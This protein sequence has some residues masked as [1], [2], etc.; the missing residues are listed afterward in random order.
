SGTVSALRKGALRMSSDA[1]I[2]K[3]EGWEE[4]L[5]DVDV[6]GTRSI[7]RDLGALK[8]QLEN[9]EPDG[10]RVRAIMSRLADATMK[11]ADKA[12][13]RSSE[14]I[15]NLGEVLEEAVEEAGDQDEEYEGRSSRSRSQGARHS[16]R[17]SERE[18]DEEYDR[19][20]RGGLGY[21]RRGE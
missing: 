4:A 8:R 20:P 5:Q 19:S 7:L 21:G 2:R 16:Q 6:P 9:D 17:G 14:K 15:R 13:D 10:D 18:E 12:D 11:I 3:I 1:A